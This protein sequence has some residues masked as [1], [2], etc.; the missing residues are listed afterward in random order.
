LETPATV[1]SPTISVVVVCHD[2]WGRLRECLASVVGQSIG[3]DRLELIAI[4]D[5][6]T[7]GSGRILDEYAARY[8][9]VTV[10][11]EPNSGGPGRPRNV[12]L[13]RAT[14]RF[15]FFLDADDYLGV[16]ALERL[17]AMAE[18]N[19]SDIVLGKIVGIEGRKM[20]RATG[21]FA[22]N[23]DRVTLEEAYTSSNVLKL[24]RRSFLERVG[25]RFREGIAG[26]ED[27][28]FMARVYLE[29]ATI[30]VVADYDCYF[31][32]RRAGSQTTRKDRK[33]DLAEYITRL[34]RDRIGPVVARRKP[35]R[36]RDILVRKH[37]RKLCRKF[38]RY[39]R[40]LEPEERRRVFDV[41]SAV[42]RRWH[43]DSIQRAMPAREAIRAHCLKQGLL[44][45]LEDIVACSDGAAFRD[46]IVDRGRIYARYPHFRDASGIPDSCFDITNEVVPQQR[47]TRAA[48]AEGTLH[49]SGEAYMKLVGG[50]TTVELHRWPRGA[51]WPFAATAVPT[52]ELRDKAVS[53]ARAGFDVS[54]DLSTAAGGRPLPAG[55]WSI[56]L[57]VGTDGIHRVMPL[58]A[59][60]RPPSSWAVGRVGDD[61]EPA[62]LYVNRARELR[63]RVG[64]PRRAVTWLERA[65]ASYIRLAR[66]LGWAMG[67]VRASRLIRAAVD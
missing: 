52:P 5:G 15:V 22:S 50:A 38:G 59:P 14:G 25:L 24:F 20:Y 57:A 64:R 58:V 63:L 56:R 62:A 29:A 8:P 42:V 48:V 7:D 10:C 45:E 60:R 3:L 32:R 31:T 17:V 13:D 44:A 46:P 27:G 6:S 21:V 4:D 37:I 11:H 2:D 55:T 40:A 66:R 26:G 65:E 30:S 67:R 36:G 41:G 34:E 47:L 54:I 35:G 61:V 43:T 33:D 12:G 49:L 53:Y 16:E 39:W 28:D 18:R 51:T 9:Q 19:Q 1:R 23:Q